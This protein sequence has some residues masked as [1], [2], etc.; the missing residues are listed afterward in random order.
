ML[1]WNHVEWRLMLLDFTGTPNAP[2]MIRYLYE[3]LL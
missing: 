2:M 1:T 3:E